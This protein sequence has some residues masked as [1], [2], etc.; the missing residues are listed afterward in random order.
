MGSSP[1]RAP[2]RSPW[3]GRLARRA[4]PP[5]G[6]LRL[7]FGLLVE[8]GVVEVLVFVGLVLEILLVLVEILVF[9]IFFIEVRVIKVFV[10]VL[11]VID[12]FLFVEIPGPAPT[13]ASPAEN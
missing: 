4:P 5:H 8:V 6:W 1:R 10:A 9:E 13:G 2:N 11:V 12:R 7:F 3:R